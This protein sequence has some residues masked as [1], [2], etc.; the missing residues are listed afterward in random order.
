[1]KKGRRVKRIG[2]AIAKALGR[3]L[4]SRLPWR[5]SACQLQGTQRSVRYFA[6]HVILLGKKKSLLLYTAFSH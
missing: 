6:W 2:F 5:A 1:M 4:L 3:Q